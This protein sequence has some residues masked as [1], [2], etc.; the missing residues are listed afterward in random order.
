MKFLWIGLSLTI[1]IAVVA[2]LRFLFPSHNITEE[3]A[4]YLTRGMTRRQVEQVLGGKDGIYC[5]WDWATPV[6]KRTGGPWH[7]PAGRRAPGLAALD[8]R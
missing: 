5:R 6:A 2:A 4:T 1:L 3:G 7:Y 8:E